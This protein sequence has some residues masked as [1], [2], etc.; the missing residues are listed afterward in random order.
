M[1]AIPES[2]KRRNP[3]RGAES[4]EKRAY[5]L[6]YGEPGWHVPWGRTWIGVIPVVIDISVLTQSAF[7]SFG[8]TGVIILAGTLGIRKATWSEDASSLA[9]TLASF[10][11]AS[12]APCRN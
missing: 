1:E 3:A 9:L 6:R 4:R 2:S 8:P 5:Q 10:E 7:I 12:N 11:E